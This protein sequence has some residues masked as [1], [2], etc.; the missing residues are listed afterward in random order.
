MAQRNATFIDAFRIEICAEYAGTRA[1]YPDGE[2]CCP[3]FSPARLPVPCLPPRVL[4]DPAHAPPFARLDDIDVPPRVTPDTMDRL[5]DRCAPTRQTFAIQGYDTEHAG[6]MFRN[7]HDVLVVDVEERR[8]DQLRR[9]DCLKFAVEIEDLHTIIL[10]IRHQQATSPV[11]PD[12]MRQIELAGTGAR[13]TPGELVATV[14]GELVN[15]RV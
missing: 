4:D 1:D 11:I 12:P 5:V 2:R 6:V 14:G 13:L 9:P 3:V 10:T 15:P 8:P 7:I